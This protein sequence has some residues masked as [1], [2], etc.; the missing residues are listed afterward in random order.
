MA[1]GTHTGEACSEKGYF[2][3][4]SIVLACDILE[5]TP[6]LE[7]GDTDLTF[8]EPDT[9]AAPVAPPLPWPL[10][11]DEPE[12]TAAADGSA[13]PVG[14]AAVAAGT[15]AVAAAAPPTGAP[16]AGSKGLPPAAPAAAAAAG[17]DSAI[18]RLLGQ[19]GLQL[20]TV[21]QPESMAAPLGSMA[22][23]AGATVHIQALLQKKL[24]E[25]EELL[26]SFCKGMRA[27]LQ[28]L[29]LARLNVLSVTQLS[30]HNA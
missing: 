12:A 20:S 1:V 5:C 2:V 6:W 22:A 17:K 10:D 26:Q 8:S 16:A 15:A 24:S 7:F 18:A 14:G 28:V 4:D 25:D 21:P 3:K 11:A 9:D 27:Y 19:A 29:P 30:P 13:A 23:A